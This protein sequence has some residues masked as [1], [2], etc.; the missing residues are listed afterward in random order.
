MNP[1]TC[2]RNDSIRIPISGDAETFKS[3]K[4]SLRIQMN[5][6][7]INH[8]DIPWVETLWGSITYSL[9]EPHWRIWAL[10][11]FDTDL[12]SDYHHLWTIFPGMVL[13]LG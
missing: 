3:G 9:F 7:L 13:T 6:A 4:K 5:G 2:G 12:C 8:W 11:R 10:G 1:D